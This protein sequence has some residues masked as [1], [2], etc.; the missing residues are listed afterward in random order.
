MLNGKN[1][2][3]NNKINLINYIILIIEYNEA[4]HTLSDI[5][6]KLLSKSISELNK[7]LERFNKKKLLLIF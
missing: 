5:D 6:R 7:K 2:F 1:I 3:N 4:V